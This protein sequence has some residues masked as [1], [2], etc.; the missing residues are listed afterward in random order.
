MTGLCSRIAEIVGDRSRPANALYNVAAPAS[1]PVRIA[2][3]QC[4]KMFSVFLHVS[5]VTAAHTV[6]DIGVTGDR[7]YDHSNYLEAWYPYKHHVTA[8]G[9]DDASLSQGRLSGP[10]LRARGRPKIAIPGSQF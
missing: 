2:T 8:I 7:N 1:L 10:D 9:I 6:L 5:G 4:R 3:H